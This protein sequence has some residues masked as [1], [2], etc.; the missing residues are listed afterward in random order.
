MQSTSSSSRGRIPADELEQTLQGGF[1]GAD[2]WRA[3]ELAALITLKSARQG[4]LTRE[5][6]RL[7][8]E[9][10]ED[11]PRVAALADRIQR[12][13]LIKVAAI[14]E[15]DRATTVGPAP[16][17]NQ[18]AVYGH[19]RDNQGKPLSGLTVSLHATAREQDKPLVRIETDDQGYFEATRSVHQVDRAVLKE[20]SDAP[21]NQRPAPEPQVFYLRVS[22]PSGKVRYFADQPLELAPGE[23][24]YR[25]VV[26]DDPAGDT[27]TRPE[28]YLGDSDTRELHDLKNITPQ[29][30]LNA[31]RPDHRYFFRTQKEALAMGYHYCAYCFGRDKSKR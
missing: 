4:S 18:W 20:K 22:D 14:A 6:K 12:E 19:V 5:H 23:R 11:H 27:G 17:D 1:F 15:K 2:F 29:C 24:G 10:G 25:P 8:D 28:R 3:D 7:A 30:H 16:K 21:S 13:R 9:L 31:I 26:L